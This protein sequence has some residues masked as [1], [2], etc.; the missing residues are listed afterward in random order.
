MFPVVLMMLYVETTVLDGD[1]IT[2]CIQLPYL[3]S[4]RQSGA[5]PWCPLILMILTLLKIPGRLFC[6]TGFA[7]ICD[8]FTI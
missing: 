5:A 1:P 4:L 3:L 8:F 7:V 6:R 2:P